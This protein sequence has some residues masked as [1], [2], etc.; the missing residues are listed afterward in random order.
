MQLVLD[1]MTID[2]LTFKYQV[3]GGISTIWNGNAFMCPASDNEIILLHSRFDNGTRGICN[4][5]NNSIIIVGESIEVNES[6]YIHHSL[7]FLSALLRF[8]LHH[9]KWYNN[10]YYD[11]FCHTVCMQI[12][13][14]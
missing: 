14:T 13:P 1:F 8:K 4:D 2:I 9:Y 5:I 6:K 10:N 3:T 7:I 11:V 12:T